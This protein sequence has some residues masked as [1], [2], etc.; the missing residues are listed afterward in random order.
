LDT[1]GNMSVQAVSMSVAAMITELTLTAGAEAA[2][3]GAR[4]QQE[5][6]TSSCLA[7]WLLPGV[8]AELIQGYKLVSSSG[9][10]KQYPNMGA[11]SF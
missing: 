4:R 8:N 11:C 1:H 5:K 9:N 7:E 2:V 6:L 3:N 10:S